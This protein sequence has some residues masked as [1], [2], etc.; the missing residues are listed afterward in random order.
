MSNWAHSHYR[1]VKID[2]KGLNLQSFSLSDLK[3]S[4]FRKI[5]VR[6]LLQYP[7]ILSASI[8]MLNDREYNARQ[9]F[10]IHEM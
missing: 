7:L 9:L 4:I 6:S 5:I 8:K 10:K 1:S 3:I 2:A